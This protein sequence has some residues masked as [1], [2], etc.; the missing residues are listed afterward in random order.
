MPHPP[1]ELD[2]WIQD[3]LFQ[4][5]P[6]AIAMID[7]QY[8]VVYANA[9]F[10][11]MFGA[12]RQQK[13]YSVYKDRDSLCLSCK[14][15]K[16]FENGLPQ[17]NQE[18]GY[19]SEGLLTRYIKHTVP[20]VDENG[21]IP[22]LIEM[23]TDITEIE[24]IRREYQLLF[25]QV[26]CSVL[27]IDRNFRIVK[28]NAKARQMLG[29]LE[30]HHCYKGLKGMDHKCDECTASKTFQ[31]GALHTG[32]HIWRIKGGETIHLHVVTVPLMLTNDSFDMVMEMAVDV[33]QTIKLEDGLR[34]A[35]TFLETMIATSMDGILAVS[36]DET[37]KIINDSA[38]QIFKLKADQK[39]TPEELK[40]ILPEGLF[41][42]IPAESRHV[43]LPDTAIVNR[44][45]EKTPVRLVGNELVANGKLLGMA[46][47]IQDL[48][49]LKRLESEKL[50]AERLA[51][52]GQ[53]VAGLAHGIKNLTTALE[54]G[55]YMLSTG[56]NKGNIER[57]QKGMDMLDRNIY[58][59]STFV[60][61]FLSFSRGR[62][63]RAG[64]NEPMAIAREVVEM[65]ATNAASLG[66]Q[67]ETEQVGEVAPA[68]IDY[69]SMHECLTNL[70]G[71]A[72]DACRVSENSSGLGVKVRV[73]ESDGAVVYEVV[74]NG[75]GM[76]YEIKQK[77]FT[78]FFTT[79]G[80]GGSG[81]G[82]LMT[83]KIIHEHGGSIDLESES[84]KG[85]TFRIRLPRNRLPKIA[86]GTVL[87]S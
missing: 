55:M 45:G 24:Q 9:A 18:V 19:N 13:C 85:T 43:Y 15:S 20:I 68:A 84:G 3:K 11:K 72:I 2:K 12:W 10:E 7:R 30:G 41:E 28:T 60:K 49:A 51:A 29:D 26:P 71:N 44:D 61:A 70:V 39:L 69:E 17:V 83:K 27:I 33:T 31:D 54:G 56:M 21:H 80:L 23:C 76:D 46:F 6:M 48:S 58:R 50:E 52:V 32:H 14:G 77:V 78:T 67:L 65:Y 62:E 34:F 57:I 87:R 73:F 35:H 47:S 64:L 66:V 79:K 40:K 75:C 42:N 53:T 25:D 16:T 81:L 8:N 82:L 37:V 86:A 4:A 63:I 5:V 36:P 22:Y 59:I 1:K 74:D 38:M